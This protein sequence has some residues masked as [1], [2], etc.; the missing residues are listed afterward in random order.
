MAPNRKIS[1]PGNLDITKRGC[2]VLCMCR[3]KYN[4]YKLQYCLWFQASSGGIKIDCLW[5]I[6]TTVFYMLDFSL[7]FKFS[8]PLPYLIRDP[9]L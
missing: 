2:G 9:G 5:I 4:T 7:F 6:R 8:S 3:K 1:D